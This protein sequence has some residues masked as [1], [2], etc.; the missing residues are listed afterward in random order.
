MVTARDSWCVA[1]NAARKPVASKDADYWYQI[2]I[3]KCPSCR[4]MLQLVERKQSPPEPLPARRGHRTKAARGA[5]R[6]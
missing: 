1:C 4:S 5:I 3:Y 2:V 6:L